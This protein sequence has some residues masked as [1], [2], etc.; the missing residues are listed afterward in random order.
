MNDEEIKKART[1]RNILFKLENRGILE[2]NLSMEQI[3]AIR[4]AEFALDEVCELKDV[5][6]VNKGKL[7]DEY[8]DSDSD[9]WRAECSNCGSELHSKFGR[10]SLIYKYCPN[11]GVK[12]EG[13]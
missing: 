7:E 10:L 1:A 4:I 11:C 2:N 8:F 13:D 12:I 6:P 9:V 5:Q 3:T